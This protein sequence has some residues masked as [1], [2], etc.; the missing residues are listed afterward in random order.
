MKASNQ[1]WSGSRR[2]NPTKNMVLL[3]GGMYFM[4]S[5][6]FYPE[7]RPVRPIAVDGFWIDQHP[8]TVAEFRRFVKATGYATR[9][10]RPLPGRVLSA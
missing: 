9:A 3:E 7:E 4:G 2:S 6:D 8:V 1:I 10:E 5:S